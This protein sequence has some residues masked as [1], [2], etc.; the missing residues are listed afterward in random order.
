VIAASLLCG[1]AAY[2]PAP[3]DPAKTERQFQARTLFNP[4]LCD[5]LKANLGAM[6]VG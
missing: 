6:P 2:K 5:Y 1:C 4:G 3:L